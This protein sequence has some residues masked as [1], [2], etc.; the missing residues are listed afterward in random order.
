MEIQPFK[1]E[2]PEEALTDLQQRLQ[3]ARWP[4]QIYAADW[5]YGANLE[6][7]QELIAYWRDH[8]DW[9]EQERKINGFAHYRADVD[10]FGIHFIHEP[11]RGPNP[12]PLLGHADLEFG[13]PALL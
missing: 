2:I 9:R 4:D 11:G 1:I 7:M 3:Q 12:M 13:Q 5:R 6:Y 8:F 10:G